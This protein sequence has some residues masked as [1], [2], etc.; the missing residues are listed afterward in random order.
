MK[1]Y[2]VETVPRII[3]VST[4]QGSQSFDG[5]VSFV[6]IFGDGPNSAQLEFTVT[7][8]SQP[9]TFVVLAYP[10][11]EPQVFA[12]MTTLVTAA[13]MNGKP[14][15]V[16]YVQVTGQTDRAIGIETA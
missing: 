7:G 6:S 4:T 1:H 10:S 2:K 12:A 5:K 14:V 13:Y 15:K 16:T 9:R 11:A 8:A 3:E